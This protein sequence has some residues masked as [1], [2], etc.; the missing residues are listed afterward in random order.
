MSWTRWVGPWAPAG[1]HK[2]ARRF[3]IFNRGNREG[4]MLRTS[5][6]QPIGVKSVALAGLSILAMSAS[7]PAVAQ[8]TP[9]ASGSRLEE[10]VVTAQKRE[11]R[12]QEVPV[13]ITAVSQE[14]L[15]ANR[16]TTVRDLSALAPNLLVRTQP[17]GGSN[18]GYSM[19]G[20]VNTGS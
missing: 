13:A 4:S 5:M 14:T 10:I 20:Y 16:I 2:H 9:A 11:Q 19:R 1:S 12:L 6:N 17:G 3:N 7:M 18:P 8:D 15:E